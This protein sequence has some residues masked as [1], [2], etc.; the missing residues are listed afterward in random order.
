MH[1][2]CCSIC[3]F[4]FHCIFILKFRSR[5]VLLIDQR[6]VTAQSLFILMYCI[7]KCV[8]VRACVCACACACARVCVCGCVCVSARVSV[9]VPVCVC[10]FV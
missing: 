3:L 10:L 9:C 7:L 6:V 2:K 1:L 4:T 5:S 8:C